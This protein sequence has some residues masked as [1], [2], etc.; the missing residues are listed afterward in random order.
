MECIYTLRLLLRVVVWVPLSLQ[1]LL[2]TRTRLRA[3]QLSLLSIPAE[4]F[5]GW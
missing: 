3:L 5:G 4:N 1:Q 2:Y